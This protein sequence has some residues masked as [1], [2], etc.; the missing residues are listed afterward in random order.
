L[1]INHLK[2]LGGAGSNLPQEKNGLE[3]MQDAIQPPE[4]NQCSW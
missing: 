2:A 1:R 4:V 3:A